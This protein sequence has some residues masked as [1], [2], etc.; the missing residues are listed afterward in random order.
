[1]VGI[2]LLL[3]AVNLFALFVDNKNL[4]EKFSWFLK[5]LPWMIILP[6]LANTTGWILT[7]VGRFPWVV[8][9]LLKMEDG[10]SVVITGGMLLTSLLGFLLVYGLLLAATLFLLFKFAKAGPTIID[11]PPVIDEI[12][13]LLGEQPGVAVG[14]SK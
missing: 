7:E 5:L 10:V 9:G 3:I 12:T 6:Y 13:P 8:Y 14:G 1:M 4:F 2:G 11:P